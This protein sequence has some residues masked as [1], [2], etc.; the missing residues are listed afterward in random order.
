MAQRLLYPP[1]KNFTQK[2][3]LAQLLA[4]T[5]SAATLN[6]VTSIQNLP[7]VMIID[8]VDSNNV[9]TPNKREVVPYTAVSGSTVT[10]LTRNADGPQL[11]RFSFKSA[12]RFYWS[13]VHAKCNLPRVVLRGAAHA[14]Y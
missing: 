4:G 1:T 3:L 7:G 13:N 8:R 10:G 12:V 14:L 6:N 11:W 5:T 2:T 9:E